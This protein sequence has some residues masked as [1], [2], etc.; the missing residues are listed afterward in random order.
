[1]LWKQEKTR[2]NSYTDMSFVICDQ[3]TSHQRKVTIFGYV[4][5]IV[6]L[7]S[8]RRFLNKISEVN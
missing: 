1:M 2:V 8:L 6:I 3:E 4:E 5:R 7:Y